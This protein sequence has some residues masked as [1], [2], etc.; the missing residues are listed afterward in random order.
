[1]YLI[2][3]RRKI[4]Q[5]S[6][7]LYRDKFCSGSGV[8]VMEN[9]FSLEMFRLSCWGRGLGAGSVAPVASLTSLTS[10][11]LFAPVASLASFDPFDP[12]DKNCLSNKTFFSDKSLGF[13]SGSGVWFG[14]V[15]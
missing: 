5:F 8:R 15:G 4:I 14:S 7:S 2:D 9:C 3:F 11:A 6:F 12:F 13:C 10:M 1:M